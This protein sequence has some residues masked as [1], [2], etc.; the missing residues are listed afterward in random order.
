MKFDYPNYILNFHRR[1]WKE[2]IIHH[3]GTKDGKAYDTQAIR[4]WH[5]GKT[6]S[7]N[8]KDMNYNPYVLKPMMDI[9]Y[10]F[11]I[12]LNGDRVEIYKGRW[13]DWNGAHCLGHN[14]TGI[15]I[16]VI[17]NYDKD[18]PSEHHYFMCASLCRELMKHFSIPIDKIYPH[19]QFANKTCPGNKFDMDLFKNKY[20]LANT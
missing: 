12:E 5:T 4:L 13:L 6:G 11:L 16:C 10:H 2:I 17:G 9:G 1:I 18:I 15:G 8:P 14:D 7:S 19:K 3:S 20:I